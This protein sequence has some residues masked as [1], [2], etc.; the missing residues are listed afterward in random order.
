MTGGQSDLT[1]G[2]AASDTAEV[3]LSHLENAER[4]EIYVL[5]ASEQEIAAH[6]ARLEKIEKTSGRCIWKHM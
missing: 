5:K 3:D 4:P 6:D 1:L 2:F